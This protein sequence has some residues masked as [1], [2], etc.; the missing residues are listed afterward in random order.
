M[1][2]I[3]IQSH[4]V[5]GHVGNSAAVFPLQASGIDVAAVPTALFSNH[6]RYGSQRG[7][8]L[9]AQLVQD[10]L[11]GIEERGRIESCRIVITGY[12]GSA[13]NAR[14]MRDFVQRS[15]ASNPKLLYLC[16]P[17]MGD[18]DCGF[19]VEEALRR[20]FFEELLPLA[21][22]AAPNA[23]EA[24]QLCGEVPSTPEEW[25]AA[26][27]I[28][29]PSTIIVTG[30]HFADSREE[31]LSTLAI[32][33][34]VAFL[35]STPKLACRPCGTGDLFTALYATAL[36]KNSPTQAALGEAV[37]RVFA[38]LEETVRQQSYEM[39]LIASSACW[40]S[41]LHRFE[42]SIIASNQNP[43]DARPFDAS[44]LAQNPQ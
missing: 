16:D 44:P 5:H 8:I 1:S 14:V 7:Q 40:L 31:R 34:G 3:A 25:A 33:P 9:D 41:L 12:L 15:K 17:V 11:L 30:A 38:V 23:F 28:L 36:I 27:R 26:A 21:D 37:S 35:V 39:A 6:P 18:E 2:I 22:I 10:L 19:Y 42:A 4:V 13:E 43:R 29:G 24:R 20:R 32:E